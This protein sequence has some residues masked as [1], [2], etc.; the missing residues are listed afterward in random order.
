MKLVTKVALGFALLLGLAVVTG[1]HLLRVLDRLHQD[2]VQ[3]SEVS[4]RVADLTREIRAN[5]DVLGEFSEKY[6]ALGGDR[7]YFA[8][9]E[10]YRAEV[11]ADMARLRRLEVT[12][13]EAR[14][15][16]T[17][18][19]LWQSYLEEVPPR[20]RQ[21]L[22]AAGSGPGWGSG[23]DPDRLADRASALS[24]LLAQ[25]L[26]RLD[27]Q[28]ATLLE[29]SRNAM[30]ARVEASA[31]D[32]RRAV[33]AARGAAVLGLLAAIAVAVGIVLSVRRPLA[34]LTRG[35]RT[36]AAGDFS[37]RVPVE[38]SPELAALAEDFNAMAARL[39]ELDQLKQD[40]VAGVSHDL[41]APLASIDETNRLL[42]EELAGPLEPRQRRMLE[43]NLQATERLSA[44]IADLLDQ[45]RLESGAIE[46]EVAHHDA[47]ELVEGAVA[48]AEWLARDKDLRLDVELPDL[49]EPPA[50]R[51]TVEG[52]RSL[53]LQALRNLITNAVKFTPESGRLGVRLRPQDPT[54]LLV[55]V[56]DTGPGVPAALRTRIFERFHRGDPDGKGRQ[57]T[58]L[59]LAIARTIVE[60]HGGEIWV[61]GGADGGSRFF[62]RLQETLPPGSPADRSRTRGTRDPAT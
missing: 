62:V 10:Q 43:L 17:L 40:F 36:V 44:M 49:P 52:D 30:E 61:E 58:G 31:A 13:R 18:A 15:L 42:L 24:R 14:E 9:L 23:V 45:R 50:G 34:Q 38:G 8:R 2:N 12:A 1:W 7:E 4:F 21:I 60:G 16:Q 57:G 48:E 20:E 33:W 47:R 55:E 25:H 39:G 41:R 6:L 28:L 46:Y 35:T 29:T 3:L 53:L 19:R 37:H 51:L 5:L 11:G 32:A 56:W 22:D 59:G 27:G 26:G 54:G